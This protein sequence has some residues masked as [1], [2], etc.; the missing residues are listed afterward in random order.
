M[1]LLKAFILGGLLCVI[2]QLLMDLTPF[3]ITPAHILV[4]YVTTGAVLSGLGLYQP[5]IDWGGAGAAVPLSGFGHS[6]AQGAI[7]GVKSQGLLGALGGGL[8]ATS[9]G[10]AVAIVFG[11]VFATFARP[12]G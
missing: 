5:L 2:G 10:V 6:L 3:N 11:L 8:Q 1:V 12:K 7:E 9:I 4:G